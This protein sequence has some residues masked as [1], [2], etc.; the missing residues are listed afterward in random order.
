MA[1]APIGTPKLTWIH[2]Q[3]ELSL[4]LG[5]AMIGGHELATGCSSESVSVV[6][7]AEKKSI[8]GHL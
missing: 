1:A 6:D 7:I 5:T 3:H 8:G 4:N 2:D